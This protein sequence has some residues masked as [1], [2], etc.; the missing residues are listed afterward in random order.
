MFDSAIHGALIVLKPVLYVVG[1][2]IL[3]RFVAV[4]VKMRKG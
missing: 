2:V 4:I 3:V 1:F